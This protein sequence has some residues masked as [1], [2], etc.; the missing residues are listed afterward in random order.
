MIT[1]SIIKFRE[2]IRINTDNHGQQPLLLT[3]LT[4][5][6]ALPFKYTEKE[7]NEY[8][9][10][11][12]VKV[13]EF[14]THRRVSNISTE[15]AIHYVGMVK[16][17]SMSG[18]DLTWSAGHPNIFRVFQVFHNTRAPWVRWENAE[19][20]RPITAEEYKEWLEP[21]ID[22][23]RDSLFKQGLIWNSE[24]ETQPSPGPE[25]S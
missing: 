5:P 1:H 4:R 20:Y 6:G 23:V 16:P 25:Q 3:N 7:Y 14:V 9:E 10:K 22:Y 18:N 24:G 12:H 21:R 8:V 11:A 13:G 2:R 15:Y 17:F 19:D